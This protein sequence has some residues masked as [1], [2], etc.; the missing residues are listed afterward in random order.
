[1]ALDKD[2]KERVKR[3]NIERREKWS[4]AGRWSVRESRLREIKRKM[5]RKKSRVW[6]VSLNIPS[7]TVELRGTE[8]RGALEP[9]RR[10]Q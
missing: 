8:R 9:C 4:E 10:C 1:M 2:S 3:E 7:Y 6:K 5:E